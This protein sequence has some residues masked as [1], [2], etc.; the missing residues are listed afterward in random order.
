MSGDNAGMQQYDWTN[1]GQINQNGDGW[2]WVAPTIV[3]PGDL[4]SIDEWNCYMADGTSGGGVAGGTAVTLNANFVVTNNSANT[5]TFTLVMT[6]NSGV[7]IADA[8]MAGSVVGTVTDLTF[9]DATVAAVGGS[10]I[11]KGQIDG[12]TVQTLLDDPFS[13]N[14]GGALQSSAVGPEDFGTPNHI[15]SGEDLD[16]SISIVLEFTLTAGDSA[17][18]SA[19]FE[20]IPAPAALP[21]L[22]GFG[23]LGR[24]RRRGN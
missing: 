2:D 15:A 1:V 10:S 22:A 24:R 19:V 6:L 5:E 17:S 3:G 13:Q 16:T 12:T 18:F 11:Y 21:L 20:V 7:V 14:A 23:L 4:W 8:L 9:D